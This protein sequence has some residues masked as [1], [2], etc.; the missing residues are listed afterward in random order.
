M[1]AYDNNLRQRVIA[2]YQE[3]KSRNSISSDL[4]LS[5]GTVCNWIK[6]YKK[7]GETGLLTKYANCGGH[8]QV[9]VEIKQTAIKLKEEHED[10]GAPYILLELSRQYRAIDLPSARQLQRYFQKHGLTKESSTLPKDE[11]SNAWSKEPLDRIQVDAK[12][13]LQTQDGKWS[14]Y[15]T[16]TDEATGAVLDAFVFPP[17]VYSS[18]Q[19]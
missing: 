13:Q 14:S 15:L 6:S 2:L 1:K 16:F 10:W 18:G 4:A 11:S 12:E 17:Q 19:P 3:G 5:Y 7:Y 8:Q 9:S